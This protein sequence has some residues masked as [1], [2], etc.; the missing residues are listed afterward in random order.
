MRS[1]GLRNLNWAATAA[2]AA[3]LLA[4]CGGSGPESGAVPS[5]AATA[6]PAAAAEAAE[7]PQPRLRAQA[8]PTDPALLA[9]ITELLDFAE[10]SFPEFFPTHEANQT[11]DPYVF[12]FYPRTGIYLGVDGR[13]VRVLGGP[14]GDLPHDVGTLDD[15]ACAVRLASCVAPGFVRAPVAATVAPGAMASFSAELSGGPS[16]RLQWLRDGVPIAGATQATYAFTAA[17]SDH[18]ARFALRAENAKGSAQTPEVVLTVA[19]A[20]DTAAMEALA[21]SRGCFDC[22]SIAA[23][24]TGP[25]W[26]SVAQR[27]DG[28]TGAQAQLVQSLLGG[29]SRRWGFSAMGPQPVTSAEANDLAAWILTLK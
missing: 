16:I 1:R 4:G 9:E 20:I 11:F 25:A 27:Y 21:S 13:A 5:A 15:F 24:R 26:R 23:A 6:G 12:R 8:L 7:A 19:R 2:V 14:F 10:R 28:V 29:S 22:H 3:G 17:Q 18:G